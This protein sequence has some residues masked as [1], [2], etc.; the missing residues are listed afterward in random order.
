MQSYATAEEIKY[1]AAFL[2]LGDVLGFAHSRK[3][4]ERVGA[5]VALGVHIRSS[6][7]ARADMRVRSA[8]ASCLLT[9]GH[10]S[11]AT[12]QPR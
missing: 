3:T 1:V 9:D 10:R 12:G 6:A 4:A 11:S 5:A 8:L 2:T 7:Q